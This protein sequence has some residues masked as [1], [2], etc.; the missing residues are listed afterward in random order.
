M[1][2]GGNMDIDELK[3]AKAQCENKIREAIYIFEDVTKC[4]ELPR[5]KLRGIKNFYKE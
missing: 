4:N 5:S 1:I 2:D 3:K